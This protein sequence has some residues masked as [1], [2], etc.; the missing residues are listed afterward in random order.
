M[1]NSIEEIERSD[2]IFIIGSNTS[3]A[4]PLIATRVF[5]AKAKGAKLIVADPRNIQLSRFADLAVL[6]VLGNDAEGVAAGL[7]RGA[8]DLAHQADIAGAV[9]ETKAALRHAAANRERRR[10]EIAIV[11]VT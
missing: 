9:D 1:T 7:L 8:G 2:C 5:R 6:Q 4:H 11:A 10:R 3:V